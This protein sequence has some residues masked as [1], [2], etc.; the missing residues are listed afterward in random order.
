MILFSLE[1]FSFWF[2]FT[3]FCDW[4]AKVIHKKRINDYSQRSRRISFHICLTSA[5]GIIVNHAMLEKLR[6]LSRLSGVFCG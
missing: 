5:C 6:S 4:L 3:T 1:R 2:C